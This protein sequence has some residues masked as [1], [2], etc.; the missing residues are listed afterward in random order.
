MSFEILK[1]L[2][3][4]SFLLVG[5]GIFFASDS[6]EVF[7]WYFLSQNY[8]TIKDFAN[9]HRW[10]SYLAFFFLYIL[11]VAFSLPI[12]SI[13]TLASGAILGWQA[14]ILVLGAATSGAGIV[15]LTARGLFADTL[16]RKTIP[17]ISKIEKRFSQNA[18]FYLL[19]LRLIPAAPFWVV[20]IVPAYT[21]I[22]LSQFLIA[23]FLGI[24]P[25]TCIY[26][27]VGRSFDNVL[28]AGEIPSFESLTS[29]GIVLPLTGLG[30][31]TL[32]PVIYKNWRQSMQKSETNNSS[33]ETD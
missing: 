1:K 29:L 11:V 15:F 2:F 4:A 16:R 21:Q 5:L 13:L 31:L 22:S 19:A 8:T 27:A 32:M 33:N 14:A 30:V 7:N 10:F 9:L 23:T 25:G 24:I 18:F 20:N 6:N 3:L 28:A 17:F 12:A 26:T